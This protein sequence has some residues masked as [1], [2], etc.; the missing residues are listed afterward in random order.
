MNY[1]PSSISLSM[2]LHKKTCAPKGR[3][4]P[5]ASLLS[6]LARVEIVLALFRGLAWYCPWDYAAM[7]SSGL[8][9]WTSPP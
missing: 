6:Q 3:M 2:A 8:R 9:F 1:C 7:K 4:Q 5:L